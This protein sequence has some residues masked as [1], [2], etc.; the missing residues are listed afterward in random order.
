MSV[1]RLFI[2]VGAI[3]RRISLHNWTKCQ[4]GHLS[5]ALIF[6]LK[7]SNFVC[8]FQHKMKPILRQVLFLIKKAL[9]KGGEYKSSLL[10]VF[11]IVFVKGKTGIS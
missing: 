3:I 5:Y 11:K 4:K 9:M 6:D 2:V 7:M 10:L 1:C 8:C